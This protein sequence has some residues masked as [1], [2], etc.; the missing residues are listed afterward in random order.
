MFCRKIFVWWPNCNALNLNLNKTV[1]WAHFVVRFSSHGLIYLE[2]S[3]GELQSGADGSKCGCRYIYKSG[4]MCAHFPTFMI[5]LCIH[6]TPE[7]KRSS[8][9]A[10]LLF[11]IKMCESNYKHQQTRNN[12]REKTVKDT[13][14]LLTMFLLG[15]YRFSR[16]ST[17]ERK[18]QYCYSR[19]PLCASQ[20]P[21]RESSET[22]P[23]CGTFQNSDALF[24]VYAYLLIVVVLSISIL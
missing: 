9:I 13:W 16:E 23:K 7:G 10:I 14:N 21:R 19:G 15:K 2:K 18:P 17:N 3:T 24:V 22:W 4:N 20:R 6:M 8:T 11:T 1:T 12:C 5:Y